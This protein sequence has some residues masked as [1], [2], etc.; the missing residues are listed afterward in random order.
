MAILILLIS[1]FFIILSFPLTVIIRYRRER[2]NDDFT[3]DIH[4]F[5]NLFKIRIKIPFLQ[6]SFI[7]FFSEIFAEVDLILNKI[8]VWKEPVE[9]EK[10]VKWKNIELKRLKKISKYISDK[11]Q[12][13]IIFSSL[14]IR[15]KEVAWRTEFGLPDPALTGF[16]T[17]FIWSI[18]GIILFFLNE[19]ICPIAGERLKFMVKPDFYHKRFETDFK[20]IFSFNTGNIILTVIRIVLYKI[21][22]GYRS[23][24][25]I[26]LKD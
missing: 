25:N 17:G 9:M 11:E 21:K 6:N 23:W 13:K 8:R 24:E 10:E 3:L 4:I 20:G 14:N 12:A 5:F 1:L 7:R 16:T 19:V 2:E 26:R 22:G 18:K 15:C